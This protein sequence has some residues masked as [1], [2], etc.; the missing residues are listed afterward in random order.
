VV[1]RQCV[2]SGPP[3][4]GCR[5]GTLQ[6][7]TLVLAVVLGVVA[8]VQHQAVSAIAMEPDAAMRVFRG[9]IVLACCK[10]TLEEAM[11]VD[12]TPDQRDTKIRCVIKAL[13]A[14]SV[15]FSSMA[16]CGGKGG[17]AAGIV[18]RLEAIDKREAGN[19]GLRRGAK[20]DLSVIEEYLN[21]VGDKENE[22][23][24]AME[25]AAGVDVEQADAATDGTSPPG[26]AVLTRLG[27]DLNKKA[28][29]PGELIPWLANLGR[30]LAGNAI[31][32]LVQI[33]G[34]PVRSSTL[35]GRVKMYKKGIATGDS[36]LQK[37]ALKGYNQVGRQTV[38]VVSN[39]ARLKAATAPAGDNHAGTKTMSG[40]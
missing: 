1:A 37:K 4:G 40:Q 20:T 18:R 14:M 21:A 15:E 10:R 6:D 16:V 35:Y 22:V 39:V 28:W 26:F 5:V 25:Q 27:Y 36:G 29:P 34:F 7:L 19:A 12:Q 3:V 31:Q 11:G 9:S 33:K 2:N 13:G 17:K 24:N 30:G 8:A 38:D 32:E 23:N